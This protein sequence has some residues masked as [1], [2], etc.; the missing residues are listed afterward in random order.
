MRLPNPAGVNALAGGDIPFWNSEANG[1]EAEVCVLRHSL[2]DVMRL[3]PEAEVVQERGLFKVCRSLKKRLWLIIPLAVLLV[4]VWAASMFIWEINVYGNEEVP[5]WKIL[6]VLKSHG[7]KIGTFGLSVDSETLSNE[8]LLDIPELSWFAININGSRAQVLVRERVEAPEVIDRKEPTAVYARKG[9]LVVHT[10]IL[11]GT[12]NVH[13]G[14][15]VEAGQVLVTGVTGSRSSGAR[16]EHAMGDIYARTEYELCGTMPLITYEKVYTG[17]ENKRYAV[18]IGEKRI[19]LYGDS[20]A[21]FE[22]CDKTVEERRLSL[23]G[24]GTLPIVFI[25][26]TYREYELSE[27]KR[28]TEECREI[29]ELALYE[30]LYRENDGG[31]VLAADFDMEVDEDSVTVTMRAECYEQIGVVRPMSDQEIS[32]GL[33][34][35]DNEE[36]EQ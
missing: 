5:S 3:V 17:R 21:G 35:A 28:D 6:S 7:V 25:T 19:N 18:I 27:T 36:A 26:E 14:D 8:I 22:N 33:T 16:L 15:T 23:P 9:G 32:E 11:E 31:Q 13:P 12:L 30:R 1:N 4:A 2:Q 29:L 10:N 24:G 34:E 20:K